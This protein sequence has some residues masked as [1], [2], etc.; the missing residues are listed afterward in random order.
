M[1]LLITSKVVKAIESMGYVLMRRDPLNTRTQVRLL[2]EDCLVC[3]AARSGAPDPWGEGYASTVP[4]RA[5]RIDR[6]AD[7]VVDH[8]TY[9]S[10]EKPRYSCSCAGAAKPRMPCFDIPADV[11]RLDNAF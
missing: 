1:D 2:R 5:L 3:G 11:V 9:S 8:T 6:S 10:Q 4:A 7:V